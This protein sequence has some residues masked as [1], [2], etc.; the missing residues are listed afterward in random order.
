MTSPIDKL[1][2]DVEAVIAGHRP[3]A[4]GVD[5][6]NTKLPCLDRTWA[7]KALKLAEWIDGCCNCYG[8]CSHQGILAEVAGVSE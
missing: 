5:C 2:A 6:A 7:E 1:R 4:G 8:H 3:C